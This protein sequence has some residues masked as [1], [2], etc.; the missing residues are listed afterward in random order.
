M[1]EPN[2]RQRRRATEAVHAG[3]R[4]RRGAFTPV[5]TP[6]YH[7]ATFLYDTAAELDG[8]FEAAPSFVYARHGNPTVHAL[9]Q[10]LATLE[11]GAVALACASGMAALHAALL[12]CEVGPGD[13]VVASRDLYGATGG[14]LNTIFAPLGVEAVFVDVGDAEATARALAGGRSRVLLAETLSNPLLRVA[15][16]PALADLAHRH[17]AQLLLDATF[18][19][20]VLLRPLE[21]GADLVTHST[22]KYFGGHGDVLGGAVIG[23]AAYQSPLRAI[24]RLTGGIPGPTEAWLTLR[25]LKTL[26]LRLERQCRNAAAIA[27][28]LAARPD[29]EAVHYPG[30]PDHPQHE[31]AAC[32]F[33]PGEDGPQFGAMVAFAIR[34]ADRA[35]VFRFLD[36]L[37][38]CLHATSLGDVYTLVAYPAMAS[39]RDVPAAQRR[40]VGIGDGL[41][42]LSAGIEHV[43]DIIADLEQAL[44][45]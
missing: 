11:G 13:R 26:P 25:G 44:D 15:D 38:L 28:W 7:A 8:A 27:R 42:R 32:L 21:H 16:L 2:T 43:D 23:G 3:E 17:G 37:E 40:R 36:R 24:G 1:S 18:T 34:D 33:E 20:P 9:E 30:L 12:A 5:S 35:R 14:L 10:A 4:A 31:L 29:V 45:G 6:I 19:P 22:T 41:V 39:H